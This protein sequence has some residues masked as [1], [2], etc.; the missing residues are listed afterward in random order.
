MRITSE[1]WLMNALEGIWKAP[2]DDFV[3]IAYVKALMA[4]IGIEYD[5]QRYKNNTRN[6]VVTSGGSRSTKR[7]P[8]KSKA[9]RIADAHREAQDAEAKAKL[10]EEDF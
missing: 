5:I 10:P 4:A 6:L 2:D 7:N 8:R 3:S 9:Q 1:Q